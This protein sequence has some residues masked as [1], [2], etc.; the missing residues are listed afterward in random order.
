MNGAV[1]YRCRPMPRRSRH[2]DPGIDV[3]PVAARQRRC[4]SQP[5]G[6]AAGG[7]AGG[8]AVPQPSRA[9]LLF[10]PPAQPFPPPCRHGVEGGPDRALARHQSLGRLGPTGTILQGSRAG[11][12]SSLRRPRPRQ[13]LAPFRRP[14]RP[15]PP[16]ASPG[17]ALGRPRLHP[18][19]LGG[20]GFAG[21]LAP[22]PQEVWPGHDQPGRG[23]ADR[24]V[25]APGPAGTGP[26]GRAP[27]AARGGVA[28]RHRP[29]SAHRR[30]AGR[31]R[32]AA[33]AGFF[34]PPPTTRAPSGC[35]PPP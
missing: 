28:V 17:H 15:L 12:P 10:R 20:V 11:G 6:A 23:P 5:D 14:H 25:P 3:G 33:A 16:R 34:L 26:L 35:C 8:L 32:A 29:R 22:L 19:H 13:T 1:H 27:R 21:C 9:R 31:A 2:G 18:G 4:R 24:G 30:V 7:P